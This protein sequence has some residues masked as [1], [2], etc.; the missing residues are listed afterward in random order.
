MS[1]EREQEMRLLCRIHAGAD[2]LPS[3]AVSPH[4]HTSEINTPFG[5]TRLE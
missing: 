5:P 2:M 4:R 1:Q 3:A